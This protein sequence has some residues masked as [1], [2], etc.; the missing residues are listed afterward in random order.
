MRLVHMEMG[1]NILFKDNL[2]NIIVIENPQFMTKV[3]QEL[4]LQSEGEQGGFVLSEGD[5]LLPLSKSLVYVMQP[6][7]I[8][9]NDKKFLN[10]I[11][12]EIKE[13]VEERY[14]EN[15]TKIN[16][17]IVEFLAQIQEE[18]VYPLDFEPELDVVGLMKLFD[19]KIEEN[20]SYLAERIIEY[21]KLL[22][23]LCGYKVF[24]FVN[25]KMY[26]TKQ[27]L[28]YLYESVFY[29]KINLILIENIDRGINDDEEGC[30]IDKDGCLIS[31]EK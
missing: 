20:K 18:V 3:L 8:S 6:I 12:Q 29:S 30:I 11:Y 14:I 1:I 5:K 19:V 17:M 4:Y 25:L 15:K 26:L 7:T 28:K 27:E 2:V 23:Q 24:V 21:I 22:S 16:S 9:L 31:L 13:G 10:K